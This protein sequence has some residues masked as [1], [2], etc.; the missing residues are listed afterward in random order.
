MAMVCKLLVGGAYSTTE[1]SQSSI[2]EWD[3]IFSVKRKGLLK[4][5]RV[6][7]QQKDKYNTTVVVFLS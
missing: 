6:L 1:V 3:T 4:E 5:S 7:V 2:I